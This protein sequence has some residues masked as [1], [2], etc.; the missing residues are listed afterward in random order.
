[1]ARIASGIVGGFM[2]ERERALFVY[3]GLLLEL[4]ELLGNC[5]YLLG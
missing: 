1:M 3:P 5:N 2:K 4:R